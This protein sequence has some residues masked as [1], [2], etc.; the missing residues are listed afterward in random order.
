LRVGG[1]PD[2]HGWLTAAKR[3]IVHPDILLRSKKHHPTPI[4]AGVIS[5]QGDRQW[6]ASPRAPNQAGPPP[7]PPA[8]RFR[9][10]TEELPAVT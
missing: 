4:P 6:S 1:G 3:C 5:L 9:G 2:K 7:L 8:G 10:K